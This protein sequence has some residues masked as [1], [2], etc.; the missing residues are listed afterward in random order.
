MIIIIKLERTWGS[1]GL[2]ADRAAYLKCCRQTN[3]II[4]A[5]RRNFICLQLED[6][7]DSKK[8]W[9]VVKYVLHNDLRTCIPLADCNKLFTT[10]AQ[11]FVDNINTPVP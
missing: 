5:S 7:V 1:S 9:L 4:N 10:F 11:F 6:S 8:R 2:N 3:A